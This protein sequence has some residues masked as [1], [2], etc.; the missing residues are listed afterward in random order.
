MDTFFATKTVTKSIRGNTCCQIFA[1]DKGFTYVEPMWRWSDMLF[2]LKSFAKEVGIL[3]AFIVDTAK[4]QN[5]I[6]VKKFLND[7]G[8][9][10]RTLEKGT[11]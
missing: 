11:P 1:T 10:L 7:V 9:I 4:E 3:E 8:T 2:V 6:K 5:L